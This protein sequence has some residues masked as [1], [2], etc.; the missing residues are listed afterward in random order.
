VFSG[1]TIHLDG[2]STNLQ[3][4]YRLR[5]STCTTPSVD[6]LATEKEKD[7]TNTSHTNLPGTKGTRAIK[8]HYTEEEE[9]EEEICDNNQI[10]A[11]NHICRERVQL[12]TQL[13]R[14]NREIYSEAALIPYATNAF[15]FSAGFTFRFRGAF[16]QQ[17]TD[18][19]RRAIRTTVVPAAFT[20]QLMMVSGV[21]PKVKHIWLTGP[22]PEREGEGEDEDSDSD[23][24]IMKRVESILSRE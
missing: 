14:V 11:C 12:S 1:I 13:L 10:F 22:A 2:S 5:I 19:Q 9:E 8:T 21:V 6:Y 4:I 20:G 15:V 18:A 16:E 7:L 17:F 24:D 3:N 23:S